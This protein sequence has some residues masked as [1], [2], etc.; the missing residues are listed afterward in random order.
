MLEMHFLQAVAAAA[1]GD[2]NGAGT[3]N[4]FSLDLG[5]VVHVQLPIDAVAGHPGDDFQGFVHQQLGEGGIGEALGNAHQ[6]AV[7]HVGG[8]RL[9]FDVLEVDARSVLQEFFYRF[10]IL[11]G[12][13]EKS[14]GES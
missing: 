2:R 8:V 14:A 12:E 10:K 5:D 3:P 9:D 11:V 7:K 6:I 4:V 1:G 13:A